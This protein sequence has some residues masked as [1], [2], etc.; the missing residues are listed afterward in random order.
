[1]TEDR[2]PDDRT[3][4]RIPEEGADTS[5][6]RALVVGI[7]AITA[8]SVAFR[9][10]KFTGTNHTSLLFVGIP[11]LLALVLV[12]VEP[13]TS[14]GT[15]NKVIALALCVS[16]IVLGEGFICIVMAAPIFFLIGTLISFVMRWQRNRTLGLMVILPL[17]LEGVSP[18]FQ[19]SR[20]ESV[21]VERV[22]EADAAAI[23]ASLAAPMQFDARL[24]AFFRIGFPTPGATTGSGLAVGDRRSIEFHHGGHHPGTLVWQVTGS[25]PDAVTFSAIS[26]D[27]YITHWLLW[28][29]AEVRLRAAGPG[30]T[31]VT[32]TLQ[33]RRGLDP[34]WYFKPLERY[35]VGL[36]AEY[37]LETLT[38]PRANATP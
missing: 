24:P 1:M 18:V 22:V 17:G 11:A 10:L 5:A 3:P 16:G 15:V 26:D 30:R 28:R 8:A 34:V 31:L 13:K 23:R 2:K 37:L 27:S 36:A 21:T 4:D 20:E 12:A 38:T 7:L 19:F 9:L 6:R 35:G 33:Y 32:W 14:T 25:A 29:R